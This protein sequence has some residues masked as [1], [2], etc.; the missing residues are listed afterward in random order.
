M[1]HCLTSH[2]QC[3][4]PCRHLTN[5]DAALTQSFDF[6]T[7]HFFLLR[8]VAHDPFFDPVS[9]RLCRRDE[10]EWRVRGGQVGPKRGLSG[11]KWGEMVD[12]GE[13]WG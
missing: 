7:R 12:S 1:H 5:A 4:Q 6:V 8:L 10:G 11:A 9:A 2:R 3:S 13:K